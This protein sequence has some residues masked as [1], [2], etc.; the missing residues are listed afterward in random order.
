MLPKQEG[1]YSPH[2][3]LNFLLKEYFSKGVEVTPTEVG[4]RFNRTF[5]KSLR[6]RITRVWANFLC[7]L[8]GSLRRKA[9]IG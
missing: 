9:T 1:A 5:L 2:S 3:P 6:G 4:R 7:S 8:R